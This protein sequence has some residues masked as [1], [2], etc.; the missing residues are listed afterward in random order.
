[1]HKTNWDDYRYLI[2]VMEEGS[3]NA[4]A[5]R[6]GVNHATV[7]RRV[8]AFEARHDVQLFERQ[9]TGYRIKSA[10]ANFVAALTEVRN[11]VEAAHRAVKGQDQT[12]NGLVKITSTD[13]LC[14]S[15]LPGIIAGLQTEY[16]DLQLELLVTNLRLNLA[17]LDAE[18][19]VRPALALPDDLVGTEAC[20]LMFQVYCSPTYLDN[21]TVPQ[22]QKWLSASA[23]SGRSPPSLWIEKNIAS[24]NIVFRADSFLSLRSMAKTGLGLTFLP[25]CLVRQSDN[26]VTPELLDF[27]LETRLWVA[28]HRDLDDLP[29][30][31]ACKEYLVARLA[32]AAE[33]LEGRV[34]PA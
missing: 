28:N 23:A 4:A 16:P 19:S 20:K 6:L 22:E 15:I 17:R 32:A 12:M 26:L 14:E 8:T 34:C 11:A 30:I 9:K 5:K 3:L 24:Q 21:N 33:I 10:R 29:R 31:C 27:K 13:S 1:M 2:A 25:C 7:L 18:I